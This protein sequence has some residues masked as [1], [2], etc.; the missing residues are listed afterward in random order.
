MTIESINHPGAEAGLTAKH[1]I[2]TQ[3][4]ADALG[5]PSAKYAP[6]EMIGQ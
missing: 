4:M 2:E 6:S 3:G 1:N 5:M